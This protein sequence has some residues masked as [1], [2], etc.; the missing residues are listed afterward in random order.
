MSKHISSEF[1]FESKYLN[2]KGSKVH[3]ID[4]GEGD[5]ILFLHGN[6][7]SNYLWRNIIPYLTKQGRC[8]AP[9]LIGMGKSD[10]PDINY[11]FQDSYDYLNSFIDQLGLKNVTLVLHDWGSGLGFHYA[12]THQENIKAIVFME[13]MYDAP[14]THDMPASIRVA[15]KMMRTP[16]LGWFMVQVSNIFI[17]K[18][19]PDMI[20]RTMTKPEMD[21]YASPYSTVKSRKPLLKWPLDVPFNNGHPKEV[22]NTVASWHKWLMSSEIPK[23]FFYVS[24]GV[25][26]KKKDVK[27]IKEGMKNLTSIH[28]GEGLHFIQEDY[29]YEIGSEISKWYNQIK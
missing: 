7:M 6:P 22:A 18:M 25:A 28:L 17:H 21:Y 9:D 19:I 3:Y 16:V 1:P 11:G 10:K 8:I 29:P 12:N 4:E 27:I 15:L 20:L 14:T 24:P 5:P 26:I 23:L 13:A 2:V